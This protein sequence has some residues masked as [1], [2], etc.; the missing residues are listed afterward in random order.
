MVNPGLRPRITNF[1]SST[2]IQELKNLQ[3]KTEMIL[4]NN[5]NDE[6]NEASGI[7]QNDPIDEANSAS[8]HQGLIEDLETSV[9]YLMDMIPTLESNF[10]Y[11]S[12]KAQ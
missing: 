8:F 10:Q 11:V 3:E 4:Y 9:S 12:K 5:S 7:E 6:D 2:T 1:R